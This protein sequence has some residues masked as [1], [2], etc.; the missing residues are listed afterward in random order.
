MTNSYKDEYGL[1]EGYDLNEIYELK[2]KLHDEKVYILKELPKENFCNMDSTHLSFLNRLKEIEELFPK[3]ISEE[4]RIRKSKTSFI[5]RI[6]NN[7]FRGDG[8]PE[9]THLPISPEMWDWCRKFG[10]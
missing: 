1:K 10:K 2:L 6:M 5:I 9:D 7:L 8:N 4:I 3:L